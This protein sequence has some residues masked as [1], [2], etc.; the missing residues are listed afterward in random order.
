MESRLRTFVVL[1]LETN[2]DRSD[3]TEHEILEIGACRVDAGEIVETFETLVRP[4]RPLLESVLELTGLPTENILRAPK[5]SLVLTD[6]RAFVGNRPV[7]A[8]NGFGYDFRLL[9]AVCARLGVPPLPPQ[10]MDTLEIAHLVFPRAGEVVSPDRDGKRTPRGRSLELLA[11]HLKIEHGMLHRA[12]EDARLTVKVFL[13]LMEVLSATTP[14]RRLQRHVLREG[15]HILADFL[16]DGD[17]APLEEVVAETEEWEVTE[18]N[19]PFDPGAA[20]APLAPG[21]ALLHAGRTH[22]PQQVQMAQFVAAALAGPER[23][24]VEAPTGT[25][26]TFAY[27]VPAVA[28]AQSTGRPVVVARD[29]KSVV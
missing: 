28:W 17:R 26:K 20:V 18:A 25:G 6:F 23:V 5:L 2:P 11:S 24:L 10:R 19:L 3:P 12:L 8:Q 14:L 21:G 22:R 1:D 7:V 16:P 29:R 9:D 13:R 27:L 15:G 4:Q